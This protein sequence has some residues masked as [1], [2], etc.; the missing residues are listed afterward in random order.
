ML[1][2]WRYITV[3]QWLYNG[4]IPQLH[5]VIYEIVIFLGL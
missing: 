2:L 5:H 3:I 1:Q 4:Y